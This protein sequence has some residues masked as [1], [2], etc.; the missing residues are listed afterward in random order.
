MKREHAREYY[1]WWVVGVCFVISLYTNGVVFFGITALFAPLV[2]Q[3]GWHYAQISYV[4]SLQSLLIGLTA[5]FVG[6]LIDRWG[7]RRLIFSGV[8]V[9]AIGVVLLSR[10]TTLSM[11]YGAFFLIAIGMSAC[12]STAMLTTV[13]KWFR[14]KLA[15]PTGIVASGFASG[16][17]VVPV[18]ALLVDTFGWQTA[19]VSL[20]LGM[21]LILLPLSLLMRHNPEEFDSLPDA[22][23]GAAMAH[24]NSTSGRGSQTDV[25][26]RQALRSRAFW[27][28][29]LSMMFQF[30]VINSVIIHEMPYLSSIGIARSVSGLVVS[31]V[32]VTSI[33]GRLGFGWFGD[34]FEMRRSTAATFSLTTLGLICLIYA[35]GGRTWLLV[36]FSIFFGIGWGGQVI[37][38]SVL[39]SEYFGRNRFGTIFGVTFGIMQIGGMSGPPLAGWVFDNWGSYQGIWLAYIGLIIASVVI[40]AVTPPATGLFSPPGLKDKRGDTG[41]GGSAPAVL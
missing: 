35:G 36:L 10:V 37:M 41:P 14:Q 1:G 4:A 39:L 26:T 28:I 15:L 22:S 12:G 21:L 6:F 11:F 17:L 40:M 25:S 18:V 24:E 29:A 3:F 8:T 31:A 32:T 33:C 9:V 19:L 27:F 5:P 34:R 13:A 16:G 7:A 23:G 30:M 20:G 38:L 2:K